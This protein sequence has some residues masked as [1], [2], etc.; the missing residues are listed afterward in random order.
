MAATR[1]I[2]ILAEESWQKV[3]A[4]TIEQRADNCHANGDSNRKQFHSNVVYQKNCASRLT[5]ES[6]VHFNGK[7]QLA[8]GY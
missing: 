3:S 5:G 2:C 7:S 6:F 4:E 8:A 1:Y